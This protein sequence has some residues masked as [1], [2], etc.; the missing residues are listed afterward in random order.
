MDTGLKYLGVTTKDPYLYLGSGLYWTAHLKAHGK[1][2]ITCVVGVFDDIEECSKAG[3][4]CSKE[5]NVVNS[6]EWANIKPENAKQGWVPG[7]SQTQE[8]IRKRVLKLVGQKRTE[9]TKQKI[10]ESR[11]GEKHWHY[12]VRGEQSHWFGRK[13]SEESIEKMRSVKIGKKHSEETK[14]MHREKSLGKNNPFFGR[15]HSAETRK[16]ISDKNRGT[17]ISE[18]HRLKI[19]GQNSKAARVFCAVSPDGVKYNGRNLTEFCRQQCLN[20]NSMQN[21][22]RGVQKNH[23]GWTV[24]YA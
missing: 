3:L 2:I 9:E 8:S 12:G 10:S 16:I 17:I 23:K 15:T 4:K 24:S 21:V 1:N 22:A 5:F 20:I 7:M 18:A 19:T 13:H 14:Q 11:L 6:K